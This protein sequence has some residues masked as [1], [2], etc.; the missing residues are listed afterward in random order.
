MNRL[1]GV[2]QSARAGI[3]IASPELAQRAT[4]LV[5]NVVVVDEKVVSLGAHPVTH[6]PL[7]SASE[8]NTDNAAYVVF[9]SGTTGTPKAVVNAVSS[10]D[11]DR[12][13]IIE[14]G[15]A[16]SLIWI[17]DPDNP[18]RPALIGSVAESLVY[19]PVVARGYPEDE[20]TTAE[21]VIDSP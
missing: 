19:G 10:S 20:L 1:K 13:R 4:A 5:P 17:V 8:L 14:R 2:C 18:E 6:S 11:V 16:G 7:S 12:P 15:T 9:T 21:K 3:I